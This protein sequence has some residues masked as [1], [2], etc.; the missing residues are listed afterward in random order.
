MLVEHVYRGRR[1]LFVTV[2]VQSLHSVGA[3]KPAGGA[4]A[5]QGGATGAA[6][7][8]P[9]ETASQAENDVTTEPDMRY[10][11]DL[12][13]TIPVESASLPLIMHCMLEQVGQ[14][15]SHHALHAGTG[16]S[17]NLPSCTACWNR[18]VSQSPIMHCMLEQVGQS[19]SHH[20][21]HAGT[22]GSVN[23]PSCT[24]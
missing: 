7:E 16:G 4:A 12:I 17:V 24:A 5:P 6:A 10:Y 15:I 1:F 14:S 9:A 21:L 8:K 2:D 22:G 19:I 18:W 11:N 3:G 23:L 20:A 13:N